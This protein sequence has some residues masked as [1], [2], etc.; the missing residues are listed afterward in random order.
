MLP[1]SKPLTET[2]GISGISS[3]VVSV[4]DGLDISLTVNIT[5]RVKFPIP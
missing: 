5:Q 1:I 4:N 3:V 2:S